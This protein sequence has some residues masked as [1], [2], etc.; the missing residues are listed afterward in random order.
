MN[1]R[2][3]EAPKVLTTT[4]V[5]KVCGKPFS[6][7]GRERSEV[8][9]PCADRLARAA[10]LAMRDAADDDERDDQGDDGW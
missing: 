5:C 10:T 3:D 2:S 9:T 4:N 6:R 1:T 7:I 8:C